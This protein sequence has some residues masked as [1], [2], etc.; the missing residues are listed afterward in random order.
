MPDF[1][2]LPESRGFQTPFTIR[3]GQHTE[4]RSP[5]LSGPHGI[6]FLSEG[7]VVVAN[8]NGGLTF[9][10][11]PPSNEWV[12]HCV[13]EPIH[14][15]QSVWFGRHGAT[16]KL[17]E[18]RVMCGPGSVRFHAE[19]LFVCCNNA[20]TVTTHACQLDQEAIRVRAGVVVAQDGLQIPDGVALSRDGRWMAV[21][22][23]GHSRVVIYRNDVHSTDCRP[24]RL[25]E[26]L[27]Q[28]FCLV[29]GVSRVVT[30]RHFEVWREFVVSA[31]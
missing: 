21:S 16:R 2:V 3:V 15:I 25:R 18:R 12:A 5:S 14:Y 6:D 24:L 27:G 13:V 8:R 28:V 4:L 22:D 11:V 1:R 7:V 10:R 20:S 26:F 29:T 17:R 19:T 30:V 23:Q 9:Y 31:Q